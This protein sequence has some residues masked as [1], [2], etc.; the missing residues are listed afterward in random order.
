M[1][2]TKPGRRALSSQ[3]RI[4]PLGADPRGDRPRSRTHHLGERRGQ[5]QRRFQLLEGRSRSWV[6]MPAACGP[7]RSPHR[8][9]AHG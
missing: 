7:R 4:R 8:N 6:G 9:G 1:A 3:N 5:G 2:E